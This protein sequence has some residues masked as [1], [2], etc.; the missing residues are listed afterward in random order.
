MRGY[1][2]KRIIKPDEKS[3]GKS[4]IYI[5]SIL[6][7]TNHNLQNLYKRFYYQHMVHIRNV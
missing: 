2:K 6:K 5:S 3:W 7:K 1:S 4:G